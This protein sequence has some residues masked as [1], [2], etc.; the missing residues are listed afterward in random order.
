VRRTSHAIRGHRAAVG[1]V[2]GSAKSWKGSSGCCAP[3]LGG[4]IS[5]TDTPVGAP[6]GAAS[7]T[8]KPMG[9][10]SGC[11]ARSSASSMLAG[12]CSGSRRSST[13]PSCRRKRGSAIGKHAPRQGLEVHGGGRRRGCT[14]GNLR[15]LAAPGEATL[16]DA[17]LTTIA[18][19]RTGGGAP[20]R[21]PR[22]LIAD[23]A[24]R[25]PRVSSSVPG[26]LVC[27]LRTSDSRTLEP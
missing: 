23:R 10:G 5:R 19:P 2:S 26:F 15:H 21:N 22:R 1:H 7:A 13:P 9:S 4:A 11:G 3:A 24:S 8:G 20:R 6:A 16:V 17:T 27:A 25:V 18:V 12:D 14:F